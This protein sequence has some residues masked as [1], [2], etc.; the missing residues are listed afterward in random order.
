MIRMLGT[1]ANRVINPLGLQVS[2]LHSRFSLP[3]MRYRFVSH[4]MYLQHVFAQISH[5]EGNIEECGV[6]RGRSFLYLSY[7]IH[8]ENK[9]R[10]L[11]GF[12]SF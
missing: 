7:L 12:D 10:I 1:I 11:W 4:F 6:G 3:P 8:R 9:N 2:R 5:L